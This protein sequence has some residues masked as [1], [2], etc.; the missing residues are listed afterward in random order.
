[1]VRVGL[2][3]MDFSRRKSFTAIP[4]GGGSIMDVMP[5]SDGK[6]SEKSVGSEWRPDKWDLIPLAAAA[7]CVAL[8]VGMALAGLFR[9]AGSH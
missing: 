5:P 7:A 4:R 2:E 9:F 6:T 1:V 3:R 8:L